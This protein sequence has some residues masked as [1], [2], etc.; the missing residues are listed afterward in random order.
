MSVIP[1]ISIVDITHIVS[2]KETI[3]LF[4]HVIVMTTVTL[5]VRGTLECP[6]HFGNPW[7][8]LENAWKKFIFNEL[9][10]T[11]GICIS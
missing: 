2:N 9:R 6:V 11:P 1:L 8:T 5:M 3:F 4:V 7:K 10:K